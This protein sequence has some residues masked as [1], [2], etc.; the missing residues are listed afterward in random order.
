MNEWHSRLWRPEGPEGIHNRALSALLTPA[1]IAY[2]L[3]V[4]VRGWAYDRRLLASQSGAI[5]TLVVGN[6]TVGGTGKT[7]MAA[8]FA[9]RLAQL[10]ERPAIVLRGYGGDETLVHQ[11]LNPGVPVYAYPDRLSGVERAGDEGASVAILDDG[12]QHRALRPDAA[13]A[14][15]SAEEY[16]DHPRLLPRGPWREPLG[17]LDRATLVVVTRKRVSEREA[18]AVMGR[19][20]ARQR[21][22]PQARAYIGLA[23]VARFDAG[24]GA[25]GE[26]QNLQGF[27]GKLAVAGV[28]HPQL[29]W[30]QL[31]EAGAVVEQHMAFPDHHGY[32]SDEV[33][34]ISRE[35]SGGALVATLKD[36][37]KLGR[38]LDPEIEIHVPVQQVIWESGREEIDCML[39]N[40]LEMP[41]VR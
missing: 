34:E 1:E 36:A 23:G 31:S 30:S 18:T 26:V 21:A 40:L 5:P 13:V 33:E 32:S 7:P 14:M 29:V 28:A 9:R 41:R 20:A 8:W 3:A 38:V 25:L 37:V 22:G 4:S 19:L 27:R 6:L 2:R 11:T 24:S 16:A 12:F 35:A 15:V 10:G 39:A 17:S